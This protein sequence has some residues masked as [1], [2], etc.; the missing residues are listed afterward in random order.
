M[1]PNQLYQLTN[2]NMIFQKGGIFDD[3]QFIMNNIKKLLALVSTW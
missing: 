1:N 3:I 2:R